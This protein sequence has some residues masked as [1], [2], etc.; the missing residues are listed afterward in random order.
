[1]ISVSEATTII[2]SHLYQARKEQVH[3]SSTVGRILATLVTADRDLPP[4]HRASMDGIAVQFEAFQ[5]GQREF[6]IERIL[7]AGEPAIALSNTA[8]AIEIMTG[9]ALPENTDTVVRYE[10][11][12]I[13]NGVA[14]IKTE[15][16]EKGLFVHTQ[17]QDAKEGETLLTPGILISPAEVALLA[18]VGKVMVDV[19]SFPKVAIISTGNELVEIDQTPAPHQIRKSNSYALQASLQVMGCT[20]NLFHL[21]DEKNILEQELK[22]IL[23]EHEVIILSGGVSK[24]KF[25]YI[26]EVLT[27]LGIQK[28]FHQVSQRP[29]KPFWFGTSTTHIVFA[30]PGNP[31]STY[32]CFYRYIK[33]WLLKSLGHEPKP[34]YARL[35][36]NF[37]FQPPLT[38]FLQARVEN[39]SGQCMAYPDPGGGSGDFAN[40]KN[41][42]GFIE[43]PAERNEFKQGEAFPYFPFR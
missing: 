26:P 33:P 40:L 31:V 29:G 17:G 28:K 19:Y 10:D 11:V 9:A 6:K 5:K 39:E 27:T 15:T 35:A 7:A 3:L 2:Q 30:L 1:M 42:D 37:S 43:L 4:F 32:M 16:L 22:H 36:R 23:K 38:Y 13:T 20:A 18:S 12:D 21:P 41:I 24:G 34:V 25:D 14:T 8:H